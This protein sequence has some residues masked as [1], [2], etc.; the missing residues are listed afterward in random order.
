MSDIN[1][2][3][4]NQIGNTSFEH[5]LK[6]VRILAL[7]S[8]GIALVFEIMVFFIW[9]SSPVEKLQKLEKEGISYLSGKKTEIAQ[10]IISKERLEFISGILGHRDKTLDVIRFVVNAAGSVKI[11]SIS[12]S[13]DALQVSFNVDSLDQADAFLQSLVGQVDTQKKFSSLI[14]TDIVLNDKNGVYS[15]TLT[16]DIL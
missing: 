1:L 13:K 12:I 16:A 8:F 10:I 2:I 4:Q 5:N 7:I 11:V 6:I 15:M 3:P 14:L 9:V